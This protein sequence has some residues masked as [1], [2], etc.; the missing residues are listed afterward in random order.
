[1]R[2][3]KIALGHS[4]TALKWTNSTI[5]WEGLCEKLKTTLR[6]RETVKQYHAMSR[7]DKEKAKDI[8]GFVGGSLRDGRR[9]AENVECRS[10]LTLDSDTADMGFLNKF[11]SRCGYAA[12][13]YTTHGHT[14]E[15][16]RYRIVM[17]F[18]EDITPDCYN[19]VARYFAAQWGIDQFDVCS[20]KVN[21][22]MYWPST[23]SDGEYICKVVDG[24]FLNAMD[25][26]AAYLDWRD[27]SKLPIASKEKPLRASD[28]R[29]QEDPLTKSGIVGA[30]CRTYSIHDAIK[31]YL[32][33][34]Y[35]PS[36]KEGRYDYIPGE[37]TAGVVIYDNKFA[38]SHHATDPAG[39]KLLNA[40]DLVRLHRFGD[41]EGS[42]Q[43]MCALA[44]ED[45]EVCKAL[46][47]ERTAKAQKDFEEVSSSWEEPIPFG[48]HTITAFP[49]DALPPVLADYVKAYSASIQ[50]PPDMV[51]CSV[52]SALSASMNGKYEIQAKP[53]W[54]EPPHLYEVVI[55]A[56]SER[57]SAAQHGP[58][59][60]LSTYESRYNR[61]HAAA[62]ETSR[63]HMRILERRQKAIEEQ[64]AKGKAEQSEADKIARELTEYIPRKPLR[65]FADDI[66]P[67]KLVS[68]LAE[69]D[70][71]MSVLSSEAGLFDTFA[72]AYSKM[73]NIDVLLKSYSGDPIRVDRIGRESESIMRPSLTILMMAQ[74]E[75][76]SRVLSNKTF[77]GRGL[78]ARF[79]YSMPKSIVGS[80]QYRSTQVP[81]GVYE[82]YERRIFNLLE[83]EY[84]ERPELI[85]LSPEAD[86]L[87]EAFSDEIEGKL[88]KEYAEIADWCGKLPGN[89]LR[90]A[91]LLCR[92]SVERCHDF[93]DVP[94]PLVIDGQTM[95]NAIRLGRYFL[96]HAQ[97][98]FNVLPDNAMFQNAHKILKMLHDKRLQEFNRR[99]A[100]RNCQM[101]KTVA[102]IQP[103]LDFLED[104]GYITTVQPAASYGKGRPPMPAYL[105]NPWVEHYYC[106]FDITSVVR[107]E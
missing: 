47:A 107:S 45:E 87:L 75:A 36:L 56:P 79:L 24:P 40:F 97:A 23:P 86:R 88:V 71:R 65:L 37:G 101:F 57:K 21:Q 104:Y 1:M 8:G 31:R 48:K 35:A 5:S 41:E 30:F 28:G 74:P 61:E 96:N 89:T 3:L 53:D 19:A 20:Y 76:V 22:L 82:A 26:L 59:S 18:E 10:L 94:E 98:V 83:D 2:D 68:V 106:Q 32:P 93:L 33:S 34:V 44:E 38:Y 17:P 67:E 25:F 6:T 99:T 51:G 15:A 27:C 81:P 50:V 39:G 102:E 66:T 49:V 80:R 54:K 95:K 63:M 13:V 60:P 52:L 100:M 14:P 103:V 43:K 42:F 85:T 77:R 11:L 16:P 72:G 91:G 90:I 70:G 58:V 105:V 64:I 73:P 69:N 7:D 55:A 78:T 9:L 12:A 46:Q 84:S 4:A 62:V 92:S 29:K